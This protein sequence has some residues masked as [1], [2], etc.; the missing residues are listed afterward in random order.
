[1]YLVLVILFIYYFL[2]V[3]GK[4]GGL[5]LTQETY[6]IRLLSVCV[7]HFTLDNLLNQMQ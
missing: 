5:Y 3:Y 7:V 4:D 6:V 1:M 2:I